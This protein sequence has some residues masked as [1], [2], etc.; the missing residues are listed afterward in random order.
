MDHVPQFELP[1]VKSRFLELPPEYHI[2]LFV[3]VFVIV[4]WINFYPLPA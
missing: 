4:A 3:V 1:K 2:R